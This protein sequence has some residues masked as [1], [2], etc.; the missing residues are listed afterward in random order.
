MDFKKEVEY[1]ELLSPLKG[2]ELERQIVEHRYDPLTGRGTVVATGRFSYAKRLFES[3]PKEVQRLVESTKAS[4]PFCP[5]Q[6][7]RSTPRFAPGIAEEGRI[8]VDDMVLFPSLF[9][10]ME[11]NALAVISKEH[12]LPLRSLAPERLRKA[13]EAG[14]TYVKRVH[15]HLKSTLYFSFVENHFPLSGS[16]VVH[17]HV[18]ILASRSPFNLLRELLERSREYRTKTGR[19]YWLDLIDAEERGE[20]FLG[21]LGDAFWLVPYAP[22]STYEVWSIS[23]DFSNIADMEAG[24]LSGFVEGVARVLE[25]F[26]DEGLS[27]FNLALYSGPLGDDSSGYFRAGL[28]LIGRSGYRPP[29]VS[30]FWGL[31]TLLLEGESYDAP[32]NMARKLRPY[33]D[34]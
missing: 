9:A 18:Q 12:F 32:E 34:R 11:Y 5:E 8:T 7:E 3:D 1:A 13:L 25:F 26:E 10:H 17:P 23:R 14:L 16:T 20:R 29:Y 33:F 28:R 30:D 19:N 27:C 31:Q 22:M 4:C 6:L 15:A 24:G 2:F 21:I